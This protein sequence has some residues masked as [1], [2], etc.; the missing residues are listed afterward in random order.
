MTRQAE[1]VLIGPMGSGKTKLGRRLGRLLDLPFADS[2][3]LVVAGHGPIADIFAEHGESRFRE[4]EREAV[5]RALAG[6]GVVSLGGGAV[7]APETREL[8]AEERVVLLTVTPE[9]VEPRLAG[10][11]RPLVAEG[12]I[13]AW[14]RIAEARRP[15]YESLADTVVDTSTRPYDQLAT[16][17]AD[18]VRSA[19]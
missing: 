1:L 2:D 13:A 18:W 14:I 4:L 8:L 15:L 17:I 19:P 9:A 11:K 16:E 7:L 12:G 3:K 5:T 6:G 10:G